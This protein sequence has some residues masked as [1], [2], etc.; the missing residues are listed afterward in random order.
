MKARLLDLKGKYYGTKIELYDEVTDETIDTI[1]LWIS[2]SYENGSDPSD[3]ELVEYSITRQQFDDN[4]LYD[5]SPV[6]GEL[7][8]CDQHYET[9]GTYTTALNIIK[10]I[11]AANAV[12]E[13]LPGAIELYD[14]ATNRKIE[15][16]REWMKVGFEGVGVSRILGIRAKEESKWIHGE[17]P[18]DGDLYWVVTKNKKGESIVCIAVATKYTD[19]GWEGGSKNGEVTA[20]QKA[21]IP[22]Y[23]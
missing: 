22:T 18:R 16:V 14:V 15:S 8:C 17:S 19:N 7:F 10:A 20:Y 2:S 12:K 1:C 21:I 5:G 23:P 13:K 11:N 4:V 3:R 6:Q 9:Q